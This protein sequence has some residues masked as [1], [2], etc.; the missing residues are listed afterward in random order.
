LHEG[1]MKI[2]FFELQWVFGVSLGVEIV[3]KPW[4]RLFRLN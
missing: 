1:S 2:H 3:C 4:G